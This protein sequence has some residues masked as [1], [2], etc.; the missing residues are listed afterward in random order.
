MPIFTRLVPMVCVAAFALAACDPAEF[1]ADPEVRAEARSARKCIASVRG[2]TGDAS[3]VLNTTLPIVE[4]NQVIIDVPGNQTRWMCLT[5]D[6]GAPQSLY[7]MGV[8]A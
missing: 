6:Q 4:V 3:A 2:Q 5:N 1:D 7:Q 8:G